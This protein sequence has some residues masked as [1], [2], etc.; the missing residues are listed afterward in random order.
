MHRYRANLVNSDRNDQLG[1]AVEDDNLNEGD[2][3]FEFARNGFCEDGGEG[4]DEEGGEPDIL[5]TE[6]H[7]KIRSL[8]FRPCTP[9]LALQPASAYVRPLRPAH[10]PMRLHML[11]RLV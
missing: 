10:P 2:T 6:D 5:R 3:Q 9:A 4:S 7:C 1:D 11:R 8:N